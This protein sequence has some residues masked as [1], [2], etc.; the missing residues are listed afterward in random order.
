MRIGPK[1]AAVTV[2]SV[3]AGAVIA[4]NLATNGVLLAS[5]NQGTLV[6][7]SGWKAKT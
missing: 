7:H 4:L 3:G 5:S 1:A 2:Y 6:G